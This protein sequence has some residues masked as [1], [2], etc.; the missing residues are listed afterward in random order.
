MGYYCFLCFDFS[1]ASRSYYYGTYLVYEALVNMIKKLLKLIFCDEGLHS[2]RDSLSPDNA[3]HVCWIC[4]HWEE[5]TE[6]EYRALG[7][8]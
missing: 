6:E 8:R 3:Y 4:G 5:F 7:D 2:Y 1:A